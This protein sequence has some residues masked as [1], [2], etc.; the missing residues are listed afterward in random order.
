MIKANWYNKTSEDLFATLSKID[1]TADMARFCRDLMTKTE[2]E[3]LSGRWQAAKLL[4]KGIS[5]REV[6]ERTGVSITTVTRVNGWLNSGMDGYKKAIKNLSN[7]T[8]Q[9]NHTHTKAD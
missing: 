2:I 8:P 7:S 5:Q 4:A 3:A 6:A 1:N 9:K